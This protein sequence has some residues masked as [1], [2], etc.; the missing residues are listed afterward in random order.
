M[1]YLKEILGLLIA[2]GI[3]ALCGVFRLPLPAPPHWLGVAMIATIWLG[4]TLFHRGT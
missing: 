2:F 3:G 4:Y 1:P